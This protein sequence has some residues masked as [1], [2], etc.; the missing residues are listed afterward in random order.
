M[1]KT[2][3]K[4]PKTPKRKRASFSPVVE[5]ELEVKEPVVTATE[6][7]PA[8]QAPSEHEEKIQVSRHFRR[9]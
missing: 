1:V 7:A 2:A 9:S 3:H 6:E 8:F 5:E 4:T